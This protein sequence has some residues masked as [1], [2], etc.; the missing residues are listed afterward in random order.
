M[1]RE[2]ALWTSCVLKVDTQEINK[3]WTSPVHPRRL[4]S[5]S[6]H[7]SCLCWCQDCTWLPLRRQK[8]ERWQGDRSYSSTFYSLGGLTQHTFVPHS[9]KG[10]SRRSGWWA[11]GLWW[12][13]LPGCTPARQE[14]A[15]ALWASVPPVRAEPLLLIPGL[16]ALD[17]NKG[18]LCR[19]QPRTG[20]LCF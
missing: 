16:W 15:G 19:T 20:A 1:L 3:N 12:G 8:S 6:S 17:F 4:P 11:V 2:R 18:I 9:P 7:P 10:Q 14:R 5:I 13:P